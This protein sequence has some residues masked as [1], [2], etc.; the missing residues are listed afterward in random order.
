MRVSDLVAL[1]GQ[2]FDVVVDVATGVPTVVHW[3][4]PLGAVADLAT[5]AGALGRPSVAGAMA[6]VAPVGIVP[7]HAD[8]FPGRPGLMGRRAGGRA[9]APRFEAVSHRR[10]GQAL[11]VESVDERAELA[12]LTTIDVGDALT[13]K[14]TLTN[15][16][17]RRYSLDA[18][19]ITLPV[20][21]HAGEILR[22]EGRWAREFQPVRF[23]LA[24]GSVLS[25]NQRGRTSHERVPL[26]FAGSHGFGEWS[27]EVWGVHLA[28]S[29][30][31]TMLAE[32]LADGRRY[33]QTGELLHPGEIVLE[34]GE[35]YSTPLV[36]AV[37][38]DSGLTP[39]T[40]GFHRFA[41]SS[42]A[43]P[44][45]PRPVLLN[46]WEAVY[47][48]HDTDRLCELA[49]VAASV[50]IERFVLDDGWFGSRRD[51]TSGLGD[52][53]VSPEVYPDGLTPLVDHVT[54]LGMEF[55]IWVEPEMVNPDSELMR[56]HPEWALITDG[57][58]PV[59]GRNQLVLDLARPDAFAH[60]LGLL[61]ALLG[62]S[63]HLV[64]EV[65]HEP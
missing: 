17:D 37:Y 25:E 50:G 47:F 18:L 26:V 29:A 6:H 63:R 5:L 55:G 44:T 2:S 14:A 45:A 56:A 65:G 34:A 11:I 15:T 53:W 49:D 64:R 60:V 21:S 36:V 10:D 42:P 33:V 40:W 3:G 19:T 4:A 52:W 7:L 1:A 9:W 58:E 59:L 23:A 30:N 12:L 16:G 27:G 22:F 38:S 35:S 61:D 43:H 39:A 28:W 46:T 31:H 57:Y 41:R 20:P 51:D 13:V 32:R 24:E 8:G 54:G 62:E 48:D